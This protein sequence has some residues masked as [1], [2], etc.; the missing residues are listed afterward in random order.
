[1]SSL[2]STISSVFD[3][4]VEAPLVTLAELDELDD[5]VKFH[6][7]SNF[8]QLNLCDSRDINACTKPELA[9]IESQCFTACSPQIWPLPH[10]QQRLDDVQV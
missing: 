8:G 9:S 5:L 3:R 10:N 7:L 4:L 6:F 2:L 1:M